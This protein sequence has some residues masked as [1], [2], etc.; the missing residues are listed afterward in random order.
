M[1][2]LMLFVRILAS[3][4]PEINQYRFMLYVHEY[5]DP[6]L[7]FFR[8]VIPPLGMFDLSPIVALFSLNILEYIVMA[9]FQL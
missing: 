9:L 1:F 7:N 4:V 8:Q 2:T 5:T 6:Y 3:W